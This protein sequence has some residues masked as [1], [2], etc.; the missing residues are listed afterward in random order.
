M[1]YLSDF[2]ARRISS[3]RAY[4]AAEGIL[5]LHLGAL[6]SKKAVNKPG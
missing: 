3:A 1:L 5:E 6:F 2:M 4:A